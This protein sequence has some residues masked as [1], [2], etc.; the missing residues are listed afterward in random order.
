MSLMKQTALTRYY[1]V[2]KQGPALKN[3]RTTFGGSVDSLRTPKTV[4]RGLIAANSE[5]YASLPHKRRRIDAA[6]KTPV[7]SKQGDCLP[8]RRPPTSVR[9]RLLLHED[10]GG[11]D[12][13]K[14]SAT[15][16]SSLL[17]E[18]EKKPGTPLKQAPD[19]T[20]NLKS[21]VMKR[22]MASG[23]LQELQDRLKAIDSAQ[24]ALNNVQAA[25][26][27]QEQAAKSP[28]YERFHHLTEPQPTGL[29]LPYSYKELVEIF[30]CCDTIVS[31]LFN[32]KEVCTFD[33]LKRSVEE[34]SKK[35]F[36]K[37]KLGQITAIFPDAYI[38]SQEK[39]QQRGLTDSGYHLVVTPRL[40][41]ES[42]KLLTAAHLLHRRKQFH[43]L[44]LS[45][46]KMHHE[47]FLQSLD[48]PVSIAGDALTRWHPKF[49][50]DSVPSICPTPLPE[51]PLKKSCTSAQDVLDKVK[52]RL[53]ERIEKALLSLNADQ[54]TTI[55]APPS[56]SNNV[57]STCLKGISEDLLARI[58]ERESFKLVKEMTLRPEDEKERAELAKL[59]EFIRITRSHFLAEQKAAI[60]KDDLVQKIRESFSSIQGVAEVES[61]IILASKVLPDWFKVLTIR[62]GTFVKIVK[63]TD[64]NGLVAR[65]TNKLQQ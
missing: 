16:P 9:K 24:T 1:G 30:R 57:A 46:V 59:P 8:L 26:K 64:I 27:T 39:L 20:E 51:S 49:P 23:K 25:K 58:R 34:M 35:S 37:A 12:I 4:P 41:P 7:S 43:S 53:G 48:P 15:L 28:A 63:E 29:T 14:T 6:E 18:T 3:K 62:R 19:K 21:A 13:T 40:P 45:S 56:Q 36:C 65:V 52:G 31:M 2:K 44:L 17:E 10:V 5:P 55:N 32:R 42:S 50:L 33:K 54:R 22:L 11:A 61:L 38:L 47:K 60:P